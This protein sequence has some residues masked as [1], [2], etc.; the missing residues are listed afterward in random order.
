MARLK[1]IQTA[2]DGEPE[3]RQIPG[4]P[5]P[6]DVALAG[7]RNTS[8]ENAT[9]DTNPFV[10]FKLVNNKKKGRVWIDSINDTINPATGK[11]ERM[12][13]LTGCDT[14]WLKEQKHLTEDYVK[15]NRR[16]LCFE[17]RVLR[18]RRDDTTALDFLKNATH[19][20][21]NPT[22]R[23]GSKHEYFEWNPQRQ[24][25]AVAKE[26]RKKV[27]AMKMAIEID[28]KKMRK[29][30]LYLGVHLVDEMGLAKETEA[31]RNDYIMIAEERPQVFLDSIDN[32]VVEVSYLVGM[33]IRNAYIDLGRQ[34][35]TAYWAKGGG[36][37]CAIPASRNAREY[38]V[39]F[40][41]IQSDDSKAFLDQLGVMVK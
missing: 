18:V 6:V 11:V 21:E 23:S 9:I 38:L 2:M 3:A 25:E 10:I 8:A 37:I 15:Y 35:N 31:L 12:R 26:R 30:A 32:P 29:H 40:A 24:A 1:H 17:D 4:D 14:I 28:E 33:A 22:R 5:T 13:L 7:M 27:E 39:E 20:I 34:K 19:F 16:S 36:F 41:M